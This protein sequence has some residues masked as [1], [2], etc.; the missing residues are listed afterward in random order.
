[1]LGLLRPVGFA[2]QHGE[3]VV[4]RGDAPVVGTEHLFGAMQGLR[5][6]VFG[7]IV[8]FRGAHRGGTIDQRRGPGFATFQSHA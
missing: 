6:E 8:L 7:L 2:V 5:V 1:M 4:Q 3:I